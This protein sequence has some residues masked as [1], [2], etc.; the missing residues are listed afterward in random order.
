MKLL[1]SA[2]CGHSGAVRSTPPGGFR[3]RILARPPLKD[4]TAS[5]KSSSSQETLKLLHLLGALGLGL[6]CGLCVPQEPKTGHRL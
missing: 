1:L 4:L 3:T 5:I 2:Q 6:L